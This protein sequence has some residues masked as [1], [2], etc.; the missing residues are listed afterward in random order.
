MRSPSA[1]PSASFKVSTV[2]SDRMLPGRSSR[3]LCGLVGPQSS[4][5]RVTAFGPW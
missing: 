3:A 4:R 1:L 2:P 5:S